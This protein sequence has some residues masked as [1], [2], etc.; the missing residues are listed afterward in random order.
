MVVPQ[1]FWLEVANRIGR[2]SGWQGAD[3]IGA[4]HR[5]DT[6]D[7]ETLD[8]DRPI[9]L[10]VIDI[11]ERFRLT[12]YDA[13]YLAIAE[14]LDAE[15]A[16]LDDALIAAGG[17]RATVLVDDHRLHERPAPY[18]HEVTWPRYTEISAY[19]A[20]LR[21]DALRDYEREWPSASPGPR[22]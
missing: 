3:V 2:E 21:A 9:L 6:Y 14:I 1:H 7:L 20:T 5:L 12:A 15:L 19:L 17:D 22:R 13:L 11:V 16:T 4:I 18:E 10:Q 8:A